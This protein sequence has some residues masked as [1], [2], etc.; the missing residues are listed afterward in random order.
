M[1][2][3][4]FGLQKNPFNMTPDPGLLFIPPQHREALAGLTYAILSRKGFATLIGDAGTGKTTLLARTLQCLP[5]ARFHSSVILNP[6]V[7][8][9]EFLE[10]I[11]LDFGIADVPPS[12]AQRLVCLQRMLLQDHAEG[13]T[14]VLVVDEAH[15]LSP[16]VLEEVRLLNNFEFAE[17]KLLQI[18]LIGQNELAE[19]LNQDCMRQLKQR[20]AVRLSIGPMLGQQVEEY[21]RYRWTKCGGPP[22][23]PFSSD[24]VRA[25]ASWS[26][27]IPRVINAICDNALTAAFG[28]GVRTI[29]SGDIL[30]VARDLDLRDPVAEA[31]PPEAVSPASGSHVAGAET[32]EIAP[33]RIFDSWVAEATR[34]SWLARLGAKLGL[35]GWS[36]EHE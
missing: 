19:I 18:V 14:S 13:K 17:Y 30:E 21:I 4:F 5:S 36:R 11:L 34:P 15:K 16:E 3:Q 35:G 26:Q 27:G 23:I 10:M 32:A 24:G 8:P 22:E 9:A 6:T 20:I 28:R 1:H 31:R 2:N 12:K 29:G 33:I 7:T 25:I